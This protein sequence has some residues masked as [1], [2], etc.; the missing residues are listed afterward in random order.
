MP[1]PATYL[2][3]CAI[4]RD[5]AAYLR[6]WLEFHKLVGVERFF[7]Y[8]NMS[9]DGSADLLAPYVERREVALREWEMFPGQMPAYQDCLE[10]RRDDSRWIAFIDIDEFLF[11]PTG[12][13]LPEILRE[14]EEFP[15]V[16]VNWA[17][18]G[19]SGHAVR[20]AALVTES[21][22]HRN[23]NPMA[24]RVI[25]SIVDP[26]R[27]VTCVNPHYFTYTEGLAVDERKR[28]IEGPDFA[29]TTETSRELLRINHYGSKSEEEQRAKLGRRRADTGEF[30]APRDPRFGD[31]PDE[32]ILMYVAALKEA[33]A[34]A[35]NS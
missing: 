11:S 30:R 24:R 3:V 31:E 21:Y 2:S 12:R 7:L 14:F 4:F 27:T 10:R 18:F 32:A 28:P 23:R 29:M 34:R 33:L 13:P 8:D 9:T 22:T 15:A 26:R 16:G 5:E 35:Q 19:T 6:E 17:N 1:T 25:K 20:P